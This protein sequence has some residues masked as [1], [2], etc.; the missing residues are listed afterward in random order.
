MATKAKQIITLWDEEQEKK[1]QTEEE[2]IQ[3]LE[4]ELA[5]AKTRQADLR[6]LYNPNEEGSEAIWQKIRG[7]EFDI[8]RINTLLDHAR[9]ALAK[10]QCQKNLYT[11]SDK[12][13]EIAKKKQEITERIAQSEAELAKAEERTR[14]LVIALNEAELKADVESEF[15]QG[16]SGDYLEKLRQETDEAKKELERRT[17]THRALMAASDPNN[18][19]CAVNETT[20]GFQLRKLDTELEEETRRF[21]EA[22]QEE[23]RSVETDI[24]KAY[25]LLEE[26]Y[27]QSGYTKAKVLL[28]DKE[29]TK[30]GK[31]VTNLA[32][33]LK[34]PVNNEPIPSKLYG[35][36][37]SA[38]SVGE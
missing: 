3:K 31:P 14:K 38:V 10:L 18:E 16:K 9:N 5:E 11:P 25:A 28:R 33:A 34:L 37:N 36:F 17:R 8:N 12:L 1:I 26:A 19:V 7:Y 32:Q 35:I 29:L 24:A 4:K 23:W 20:P 27:K 13:D 2:T 21:C 30:A 6:P 15:G 22:I